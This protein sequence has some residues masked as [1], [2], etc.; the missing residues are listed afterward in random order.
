MLKEINY[1]N[2]FYRIIPL[3][4][5]CGTCV[6][7]LMRDV[8]RDRK[9]KALERFGIFKVLEWRIMTV[10]HRLHSLV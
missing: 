6:K 3:L 7:I 9:F 4:K 8:A 5:F 2:V 1:C 10:K